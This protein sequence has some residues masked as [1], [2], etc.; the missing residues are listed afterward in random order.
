M[1]SLIYF[2]D[3]IYGLIKLDK[4]LEPFIQ[5]SFFQREKRIKQLGI[6]DVVYPYANHSRYE[7][8]LGV[9]YLARI[10]GLSL[11][12]TCSEITN[13][14][15][16][17]LQI[18]GLYHDIGHGP[19][20]H[21]FDRLLESVC[22][23]KE[24]KEKS[25]DKGTEEKKGVNSPWENVE[26]EE[27]PSY[28]TE[29]EER[30]LI[31]TEIVMKSLGYDESDIRIVQY[32]IDSS[33]FI[34]KYYVVPE[35]PPFMCHI[36]NNPIHKV[37]VDKMD[38]IAR[39]SHYLRLEMSNPEE[40]TIVPMLER[41]KIVNQIW[42]FSSKDHALICDLIYRRLL[43]HMNRYSSTDVIALGCAMENVLKEI[44][45]V[46]HIFE[47]CLLQNEDHWREFCALDDSIIEKVLERTEPQLID[48]KEN[49]IAIF[50]KKPYRYIGNNI[51]PIQNLDDTFVQV[52][53]GVLTDAS[54]PLNLLPKVQY[55]M[56]EE[57]VIPNQPVYL[58]FQKNV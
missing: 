27:G 9:A 34:R 47:C 46:D 36:V 19:F 26:K 49:I 3:P 7:H 55:Y 24:T 33:I 12:K 1:S 44:N 58:L 35:I 22:A 40:N 23:E 54:S 42:M 50:K 4:E 29:H 57:V 51:S 14:H 5:N 25:G 56:N 17:L 48:V 43:L 52:K 18:A 8:S 45:R 53:W 39:D 38:Y 11:Q 37:D 30:S 15:I 10:T 41:T 13:D 21:V 2:R 6:L 16:L 20:S 31:I 28:I 32:L